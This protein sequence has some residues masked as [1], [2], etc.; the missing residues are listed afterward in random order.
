MLDVERDVDFVEGWENRVTGKQWQDLRS[1]TKVKQCQET[2][3]VHT[4]R[5]DRARMQHQMMAH[6]HPLCLLVSVLANV[7]LAQANFC[8]SRRCL[9][10]GLGPNQL[11]WLPKR[12]S[13]CDI[14]W[15]QGGASYVHGNELCHAGWPQGL[16][17]ICCIYQHRHSY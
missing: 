11:R 7:V 15:F 6:S 17:L 8:S 16:L 3:C 9:A 5:T 12:Q 4:A 13:K 10:P 2:G 14:A 1:S